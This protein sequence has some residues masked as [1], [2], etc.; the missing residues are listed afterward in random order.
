MMQ[1]GNWKLENFLG[2]PKNVGSNPRRQE[3][4]NFL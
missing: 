4:I 2:L 1:G 3:F